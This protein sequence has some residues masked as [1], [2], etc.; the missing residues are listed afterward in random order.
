M[1]QYHA[2]IQYKH[3]KTKR[4]YGRK[5]LHINLT[6]A[7]VVMFVVA[8]TVGTI[9]LGNH[10]KHKVAAIGTGDDFDTG[11]D[12]IGTGEAGGQSA[13]DAAQKHDD[14]RS[15][16]FLLVKGETDEMIKQ[17]ALRLFDSGYDSVTIPL[18]DSAHSLLYASDAAVALSRQPENTGLP[19]LSRV[20][21]DIREAGAERGLSPSVN[22]YYD[23][24]YSDQTDPVLSE[25]TLLY[26]TAVAAEAFSLG[27]DE[28]LLTGFPV[29]G[30]TIPDPDAILSVIDRMK[31]SSPDIKL[32]AAF[33]YE[34]FANVDMSAPLDMLSRAA[35]RLA[36]DTTGLDWSYTE[37]TETDYDA[38]DENGEPVKTDRVVRESNIYGELDRAC[39]SIKSSVSLYSLGFVILS[40]EP[41]NQAEAI[42]ALF[43]NGI[44][45]FYAVSFPAP[46]PDGPTDT[47][48]PDTD[49]A[50]PADTE[51]AD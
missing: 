26:E 19:D 24:T 37:R 5:R 9:C 40:D 46:T 38:A 47:D 50:P 22:V 1:A 7:F 28:V 11:G 2:P 41:Y 3:R 39:A 21:I 27:A 10:L 20:I 51:S 32:I 17:R 43:K 25:A 18:A 42:D 34:V 12:T 30:N 4:R 45:S 31:S 36:V 35:G 44:Y 6:V 15:G 8:V 29:S 33:P 16:C 23:L 48:T 13:S 14:V 49:D